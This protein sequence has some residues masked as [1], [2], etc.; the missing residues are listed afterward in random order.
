MCP[1]DCAAPPRHGHQPF[2]PYYN[3]T[4]IAASGRNAA[5]AAALTK[6]GGHEQRLEELSH[7]DNML[8][9]FVCL[10]V[11]LSVCYADADDDRLQVYATELTSE[12][13]TYPMRV[14]FV[15]AEPAAV[16]IVSAILGILA[17]QING[18]RLLL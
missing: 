8:Q 18:A 9:C 1:Y 4:L 10:F 2:H 13:E 7:A 11:F 12:H 17:L 14:A 6:K 5:L 3:L 15:K 16:S